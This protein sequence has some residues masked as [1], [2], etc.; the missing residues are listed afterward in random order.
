MRFKTNM[1]KKLL[2]L[3]F[4]ALVFNN[5][6]AQEKTWEVDLKEHLYKVSWILQSN[7]GLIIAAGDKGLLALNNQSGEVVWHNKELKAVDKN[8]FL[9]VDGLPLFYVDYVPLLSKTRGLLIN[10]SNG[11]VVFDTKDEGYRIKAF[12][13]YPE[14]GAILFEVYKGPE[15]YLMKFSLKT[16][17][18]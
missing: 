4:A 6:Q 15:Q 11:D 2:F 17:E 13:M 18:Q 16:W 8:S 9:N 3:F 10:S 7:D 1:Y 14:V 12:N 5:V